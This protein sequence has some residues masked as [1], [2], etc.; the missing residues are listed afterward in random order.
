MAIQKTGT[1]KDTLKVQKHLN[2]DHPCKT[3]K[4]KCDECKKK[5]L[6]PIPKEIMAKAL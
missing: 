6:T 4:Y 5:E 2:N 1:Y 3:A